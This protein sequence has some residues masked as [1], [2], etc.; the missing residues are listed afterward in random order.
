MHYN[1]KLLNL[2]YTLMFRYK[3]ES[4]RAFYSGAE[5]HDGALIVVVLSFVTIYK[6][7]P[8]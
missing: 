1:V 8:T 3:N 4:F 2:N 5:S 6:C 7:T